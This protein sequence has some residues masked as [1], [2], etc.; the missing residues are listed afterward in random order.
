MAF[1]ADPVV[2]APAP[3]PGAGGGANQQI[4]QDFQAALG[5][6]GGGSSSQTD[7]PNV[8]LWMVRPSAAGRA[9]QAARLTGSTAGPIP[10]DGPHTKSYAEQYW[11]DM[12]DGDKKAF[13]D[14]AMGADMWKPNDGAFA[15]SQAWYHAVDVAQQYN[16]A[17]PNQKDWI[18]PFEAVKKLA[19][20][21]AASKNAKYN[22]FSETTRVHQFRESDLYSQAKSILQNELGRD[23]T[24]QELHAFT[25][26]VNEAAKRNPE[27]V[28]SQQQNPD[29]SGTN[30]V[31]TYGGQFDP[32]QTIDEM[33][34]KTDEY[35]KVQAAVDYFPAVMQA[36]GAVV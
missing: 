5:A 26:A 35:A 31:V 1:Q 17:H 34:K 13:A 32:T 12:S 25:I 27:V 19:P 22:G 2:P 21:M 9:V 24:K 30:Q 20:A 33:V 6:S 23:P 29:G 16:T 18:S 3:T 10:T 28:T 14:A 11:L 7:P 4:I 8:P 15:L 36:L